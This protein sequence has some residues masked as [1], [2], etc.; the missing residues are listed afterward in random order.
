MPTAPDNF[1]FSPEVADYPAEAA[2][3]RYPAAL[4]A[5]GTD[6]NAAARAAYAEGLAAGLSAATP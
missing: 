5:D 2:L 6:A 3:R 4:T 1:T